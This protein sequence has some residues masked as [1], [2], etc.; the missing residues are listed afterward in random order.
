M[1]PFDRAEAGW[2]STWI[3]GPDY[4]RPDD[5]PADDDLLS[6]GGTV[7]RPRVLVE[8]FA[9]LGAVGLYALTRLPPPA[10]RIGAKSGYAAAILDRIG[11][12]EAV[13]WSDADPSVVA[14]LRAMVEGVDL[15]PWLGGDARERWAEAR[16]M[17]HA[18]PAAWWVHLAGARGGIGGFKGA[19]V[20]RSSVDGFIPSRE[21]LA[22]RLDRIAA[23]RLGDRIRISCE[24]AADREY[25]LGATVYF[26]PPYIGA[27]KYPDAPRTDPEVVAAWWRAASTASRLLLSERAVAYDLPGRWST[28]PRTGQRRRSLTTTNQEV[29]LD[30]TPAASSGD[31]PEGR[32][33]RTA[34]RGEDR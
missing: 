33:D 28:L 8:P 27:E 4:D 12:V 16:T 19:H 17:R 13:D 2:E 22:R 34:A 11:P 26:D 9:G 14:A 29:L 5:D 31:R 18:D 24:R 6:C 23:L 21:N 30:W 32:C 10:S 7:S 15:G 3:D 25:P 20:R 1:S